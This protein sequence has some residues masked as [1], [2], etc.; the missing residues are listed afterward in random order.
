MRRLAYAYFTKRSR[1]Q[2]RYPRGYVV[3][4]YQVAALVLLTGHG[5]KLG[6]HAEVVLKER[7]RVARPWPSPD[8]PP[9]GFPGPA[10]GLGTHDCMHRTP[11]TP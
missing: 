2:N 5:G 3:E 10:G 4:A 1:Q 9:H 8:D 11:A 7:Y 6:R